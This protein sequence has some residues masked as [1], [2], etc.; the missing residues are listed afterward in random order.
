[1]KTVI[2]AILDG[3][4]IGPRDQTNPL[5][6]AQP[7]N[8]E[9]IK[10]NFSI[11]S[12]QASGIAVGLPWGEEGNSEIGHLTIGAGKV[13]YQHYPRIS[14]AIRDGSFFKNK[15]LLDG[16]NHAKKNKGAVNFA[17][18]LTEGNVHASLEH[19]LALIDMAQKNGAG[20]INLHLFSDGKDS[21]PH[22]VLSLI[23]KLPIK[24][25]TISGRYYALD[26]DKHWDRTERAYNTVTGN[27]TI[28]ENVK[29]YVEKFYSHNLNDEFI[30]PFIVGP[31]TKAI[32]END[33]LLFFDFR[34]DSI[35]Q[36]ASSFILPNFAEFQTKPFKNLYVATMTNY[37]EKFNV[38]VA[39]PPETVDEPL[40]KILADN[41]LAQFRAAE[42]EKYAHI[43]YFFNGLKDKPFS[44]E[45]RV[46]IPSRSIPHHD[47]HPEMMAAEITDRA[48][49]AAEERGFNF[50]LIN[51]ANTDIVAH[52]GNFGAALKA[53]ES[54][55]KEIG[56]L[57]DFVLKQKD[58]ALVITS[59]HGNVEVM[60]DPQTYMPETKHDSSPVPFYVVGKQFQRL[61]DAATIRSTEDNT[62][63]ILSDVAPTILELLN[64]P[65]PKDMTG[66][67]L[68]KYLK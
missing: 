27:G 9:Y 44:N 41:H 28:V 57:T 65:K 43:T 34:E 31:E 50:V 23:A 5:Y 10:K 66:N 12:L 46:L 14:R 64:L 52:T 55:D 36:I 11:G 58:M 60:V 1:M 2:L 33:M 24:P 30:E 62:V 17:G 56:R 20:K 3:W 42:T 21:H 54:V 38:P 68:L 45:Y 26:R 4:G 48:L 39:F 29:D 25:A 22:S 13:L 37:S 40:V 47:E 6:I 32:Q 7:K 35:R 53:I 49:Q 8:I 15:V 67:S 59:D 63:G 61:K 51:Y 18:L 16:F 19:L